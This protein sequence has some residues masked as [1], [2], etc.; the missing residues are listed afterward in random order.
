MS[1]MQKAIRRDRPDLALCSAAPAAGDL[2]RAPLAPSLVTACEDIGVAELDAV[3]LVMAGLTGKAWRSGHG[4]DWIIVSLVIERLCRAIKCR[5]SDDLA[6]ICERHPRLSQ[7]RLD[8]ALTP[9][10]E[11]LDR[12]P[13]IVEAILTGRQPIEL[14]PR[15][16][17][18]GKLP[19]EWHRQRRIL[20]FST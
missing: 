3:A 6:Y 9:H 14:T 7:A 19:L 2:S 11:L 16:L 10:P 18:R 5:A 8:L 13:D 12:A 20:G 15:R 1:L 17:M 4:G